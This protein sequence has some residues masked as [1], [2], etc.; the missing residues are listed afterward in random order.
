MAAALTNALG[1]QVVYNKVP[2]DVFRGFGFPGADDLGNM[3]QFYDEFEKELNKTRDVSMSKQLNPEL[4]NFEQW[5]K[6]NA[7]KIPV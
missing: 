5:L 3:F 2:A 7:G 6:K 1:E 4:L